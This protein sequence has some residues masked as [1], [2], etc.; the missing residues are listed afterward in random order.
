MEGLSCPS[1]VSGVQRDKIIVDNSSG[2]TSDPSQ[3]TSGGSLSLTIIVR[4]V[5]EQPESRHCLRRP[6]HGLPAR[7]DLFLSVGRHILNAVGIRTGS[8]AKA[9]AL[10]GF[11][12]RHAQR[13]WLRWRQATRLRPCS[14]GSTFRARCSQYTSASAT[15]EASARRIHLSLSQRRKTPPQAVVLI[16]YDLL[17]FSRLLINSV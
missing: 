1:L 12:H 2:D 7:L 8:R 6:R 9:N 11:K 14:G 5:Y 4:H 16:R 10:K 17:K 13:R 15:C 3:R